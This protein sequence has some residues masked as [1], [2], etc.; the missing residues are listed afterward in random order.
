MELKINLEFNQ[1]LKLIHQLPQKD[2]ERLSVVL[3]S[4][5]SASKST[6]SLQK[7]ILD[8]PTWTD[9]EL[10]DFNDARVHLNQSR[11]A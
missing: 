7:M 1:I 3:Q 11:I 6:S 4:E 2:I 10:H 9:A 8:A 5:V